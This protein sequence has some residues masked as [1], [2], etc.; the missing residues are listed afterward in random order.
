MISDMYVKILG[1]EGL[2]TSTAIKRDTGADYSLE[3]SIAKLAAAETVNLVCHKA[4]QIF[5][6]HGYVKY[7]NVERYYR[8]ARLLDIGVGAT[9]VLKSVVGSTI[10]KS[11]K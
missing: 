1:L 8:D 3:T 5:G 11:V 10:L 7:S 4:M 9:E 2:V 6:G